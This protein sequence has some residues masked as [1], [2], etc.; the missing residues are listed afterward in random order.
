MMV[1]LGEF[2]LNEKR[3]KIQSKRDMYIELSFEWHRFMLAWHRFMLTAHR[4]MLTWHRFMLT[5]HRF[6]L[7]WHRFML[8]AHEYKTMVNYNTVKTYILTK[9]VDEYVY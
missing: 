7:T 6:M 8:T 1:N 5:W 3:L 9:Y 2:I 4:F